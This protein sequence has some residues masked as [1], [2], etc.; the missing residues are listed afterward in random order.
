MYIYDVYIIL[1]NLPKVNRDDKIRVFN[2]I[3]VCYMD[4]SFILQFSLLQKM[5]KLFIAEMLK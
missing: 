4:V 1:Y 5:C 3:Y 2:G